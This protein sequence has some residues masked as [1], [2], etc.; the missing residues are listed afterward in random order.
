MTSFA[1]TACQP[2]PVIASSTNNASLNVALMLGDVIQ[3]TCNSGMRFAD[4]YVTMNSQCLLDGSWSNQNAHCA[5]TDE[6]FSLLLEDAFDVKQS[7]VNV[8]MC[9]R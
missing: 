9:Y 1:A 4:G 8:S 6:N 3:Y 7:E 2:S 5:G